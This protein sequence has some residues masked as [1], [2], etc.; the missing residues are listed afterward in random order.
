MK[1]DL[2]GIDQSKRDFRKQLALRPNYREMTSARALPQR[3]LALRR[4]SNSGAKKEPS[5]NQ[6]SLAPDLSLAIAALTAIAL[7]AVIHRA[8]LAALLARWLIRGK[9]SRADHRCQER[10]E[11][12]RVTFHTALIF[13]DRHDN[14]RKKIVRP[15]SEIC[16]SHNFPFLIS[17]RLL[18]RFSLPNF[19]F[20]L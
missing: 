8:I 12:F 16:Q 2:E 18:L 4:G 3:E 19:S 15:I 13:A 1:L 17:F 20:R 7:L 6:A 11:N 14:A 5:C 9:R 10:E